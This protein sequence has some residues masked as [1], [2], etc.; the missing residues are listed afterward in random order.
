MIENRKN[1]IKQV[2]EKEEKLVDV[3]GG[4]KMIPGNNEDIFRK[5]T[6]PEENPFL[7]HE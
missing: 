5:D 6:N 2:N 4:V 3:T 1:E 7:K